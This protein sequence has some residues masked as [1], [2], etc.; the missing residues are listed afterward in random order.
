MQARQWTSCTLPSLPR[1]R[2]A[3][4]ETFRRQAF[5]V[6]RPYIF[7]KG[8]LIPMPATTRW[9]KHHDGKATLNDAYLKPHGSAIVP[10]EITGSSSSVPEFARVE[11]P[12]AQFLEL[13]AHQQRTYQDLQVGEDPGAG[14]YLAQCSLNAL[15]L[16]LQSDIPVPELVSA[17]G[18]GDVY[19]SSIWIG[20]APT[21]TPLHKDPN[22]N[23]FAQ[24]AGKK[25][26]RLF[27]PR[28]GLDLFST[29]QRRVGGHGQASLRGEE[30]MQGEEKRQLESI[31]WGSKDVVQ[32]NPELGFEAALDAGDAL[33]IPKGWWHS[34]KGVGEGV[35]GSVNWWF[36]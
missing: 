6:G 23:L 30:M 8:T 35:V 31:V 12:L 7:P 16:E 1:F 10:L 34:I 32:Q 18:K 17:A 13:V 4:L 5:N 26:V 11:R 14:V 15:P 24:L 28:I 9:F 25:V 2:S 22:P 36:R 19:D 20:L 3:D 33:F 21:Y 27:E 29:A